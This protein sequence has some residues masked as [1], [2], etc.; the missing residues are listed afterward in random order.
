MIIMK[1][2]HENT[3]QRWGPKFAGKR[4]WKKY[5]EELVVRGEFLLDMDWVKSWDKE[6][7]EMN[8]GKPGRPYEFPESLIKLQAVWNQ[9]IGYRQVKGLTRKLYEAAQLPAYNDSST[10]NRRVRKLDTSF[11]L[12][13]N[14]FCSVACDGTGIKMNQAGEY[15]YDKYG[16]KKQKQWLHVVLSANPYT[17]DLLDLDIFVDGDGD[18]EPQIATRHMENLRNF[19]ISVDKFW[20]D[21][22]FDVIELYNVLE[23]H[24]TKSAIPARKNASTNAN[25]SMRRAREVLE[26]KT[27]KWN[28]WAHD[29]NYGL[30]WLGTEGIFSAIKRIFGEKT[31]AK[32]KE[33]MEHEIKRRFW[34]Y[35]TMRKY[36]CV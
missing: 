20:G 7:K 9:W 4:N 16:N 18:S 11:A 35:E 34:A 1:K 6:L 10:I 14:D 2:K 32:Q 23:K 21:G 25:G 33:T 28:D 5:N 19:G 15:R 29:K 26:Y 13:K 30:R 12:P 27:K 22:S 24:G 8:T 3:G 36:A 17:K 31:K